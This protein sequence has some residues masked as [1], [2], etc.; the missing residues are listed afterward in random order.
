MMTLKKIQREVPSFSIPLVSSF[1]G[2][3]KKLPPNTTLDTLRIKLSVHLDN[4]ME[5]PI[6]RERLLPYDRSIKEIQDNIKVHTES[7]SAL[8]RRIEA[9]EKLK[10]VDT[11]QIP[12]ELQATINLSL[13][14][15]V[16][17]LSFKSTGSHQPSPIQ[18]Y[19]AI[20]E[21]WIWYDMLIGIAS[22]HYTFSAHRDQVPEYSG[23]GGEFSGA[24]AGG[25]WEQSQ[26]PSSIYDPN[27]LDYHLA[28]GANNFS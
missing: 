19:G 20:H 18:L 21:D 24:G 11:S 14:T 6:W 17:K 1:F 28:Y 9:L 26:A 8:E 5:H 13:Q 25:S 3:R 7:N 23:N 27:S 4:T 16:Q 15:G 2:L 22:E 12:Q 10:R